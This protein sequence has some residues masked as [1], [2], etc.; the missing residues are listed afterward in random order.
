V[1]TPIAWAKFGYCYIMLKIKFK[2]ALLYDNVSFSG[3][4]LDYG[5]FL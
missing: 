1:V 3:D 2:F 5:T 4:P